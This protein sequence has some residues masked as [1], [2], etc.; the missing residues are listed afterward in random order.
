MCKLHS[1]RPELANVKEEVKPM[2]YSEIRSEI[3]FSEDNEA[4]NSPNSKINTESLEGSLRANMK[5]R[6]SNIEISERQL[7]FLIHNYRSR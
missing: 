6:P 3:S 1:F 4:D 7:D 2:E 5:I